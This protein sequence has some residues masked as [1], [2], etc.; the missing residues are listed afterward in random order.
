M[1]QELAQ[2]DLALTPLRSRRMRVLGGPP[3][4]DGVPLLALSRAERGLLSLDR[5]AGNRVPHGGD[6]PH[7][8][9]LPRTLPA[10]CQAAPDHCSSPASVA[11]PG[12]EG[13]L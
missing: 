6:V 2:A 8:S 3:A 12:F 9:T 5:A 10:P 4:Q 7:L 11:A 13:E 1:G